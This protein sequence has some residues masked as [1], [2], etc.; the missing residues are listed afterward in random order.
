MENDGTGNE[1][2]MVVT[3]IE[4]GCLA[5]VTLTGKHLWAHNV[6]AM[7]QGIL[8]K[9]YGVAIFSSGHIA[10]SEQEA[11]QI[12]LFSSEGILIKYIGMEGDKDGTFKRPQ[13]IAVTPN[14]DL[15]VIDSGNEKVQVI[16]WESLEL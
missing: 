7:Q 6:P 11:H 12:A 16:S 3:D 5:K 2:Y 14:D 4:S 1:P 9:P 10:V 15:V 8:R 13:S